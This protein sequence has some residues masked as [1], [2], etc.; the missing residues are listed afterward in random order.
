MSPI[1]DNMFFTSKSSKLSLTYVYK[2]S[3]TEGRLLFYITQ[4]DLGNLMNG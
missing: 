1:L 2:Q 4:V 3:Q